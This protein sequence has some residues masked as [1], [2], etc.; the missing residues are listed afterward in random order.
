MPHTAVDAAGKQ[1][2]IDQLVEGFTGFT[3]RA[4]KGRVTSISEWG[5]IVAYDPDGIEHRGGK[6]HVFYPGRFLIREEPRPPGQRKDLPA[7]LVHG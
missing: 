2:K 1:V 7:R 5:W 4:H 3:Q 6:Q